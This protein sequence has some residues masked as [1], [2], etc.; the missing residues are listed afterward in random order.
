MFITPP[1]PC[2]IPRPI[3]HGSTQD[4]PKL[5]FRGPEFD[6]RNALHAAAARLREAICGIDGH[7]Y[8]VRSTSNRIFMRCVA[9]GR[10]T[11]GWRIDIKTRNRTLRERKRGSLIRRDPVIWCGPE[12]KQMNLVASR[13]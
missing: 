10:E 2:A 8:Y 7:E 13:T 1:Y 12:R 5:L 4:H 6:A 11:P 3:D 9:C